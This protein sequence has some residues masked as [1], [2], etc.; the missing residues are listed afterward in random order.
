L[1]SPIPYQFIRGSILLPGAGLWLD[2]HR[3]EGLSFVSHAHADH[4]AGHQRMICS[5]PTA[6]LLKERFGF[7]GEMIALEWD[8][9]WIQEGHRLVLTP[10]GHILGSA[11][12]HVTRLEDGETLLYTGDFKLRQGLTAELARPLAA[13]TLIMECTFGSAHY[14]FPPLAEV[15]GAIQRWCR[16]ALDHG[17]TPVL[18]GY[19]LGKA[20]EIQAVLAGG[21]FR[22][23]VH[24]QIAAMNQ[25]CE[26]LGIVLPAWEKYAGEYQGR[27]LVFPPQMVKSTL[28]G[29]IKNKLTAMVSGWAVNAG[30][31]FSY[32]VDSAFPLS[33]H[34]DY[35]E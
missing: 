33:D 7:K 15:Q 35:A 29:K 24:P 23:A 11:M 18:L 31:R 30:A 2:A 21:D 28:L 34:A 19:S 14:R 8:E 27:V 22:I 6:F 12:I 4:V 32:R 17:E 10:A 5:K 26:A 3:G 1:K 20:Q 25:A 16:D 13:D 9:P